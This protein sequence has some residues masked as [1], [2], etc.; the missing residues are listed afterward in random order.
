MMYEIILYEGKVVIWI[1][2]VGV[3]WEEYILYILLV[4][5]YLVGIKRR[6][7]E[8]CVVDILL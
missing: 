8:V 3:Y 5:V 7:I 6:S 1:V 2:F 4:W